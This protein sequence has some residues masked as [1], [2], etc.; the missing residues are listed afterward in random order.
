MPTSTLRRIDISVA[1]TMI[2]MPGLLPSWSSSRSATTTEVC[3]FPLYS[4]LP[5]SPFFLLLAAG[6]FVISLANRTNEDADLGKHRHRGQV[7]AVTL[8]GEWWYEEYDWRAK[9]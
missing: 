5:Y 6:T 3:I 2:G 1:L 4:K 9:A 8:K 7:T